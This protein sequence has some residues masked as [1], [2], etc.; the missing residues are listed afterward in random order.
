MALSPKQ[1]VDIMRRKYPNRY[2]NSSDLEIYQDFQQKY[3][4]KKFPAFNPVKQED[5]E[6]LLTINT[7]PS[8]FEWLGTTSFITEGMI[9]EG[10]MGGSGTSDD[11]G[12]FAEG[13]LAGLWH[14]K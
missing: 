5:T 8:V 10:F 12:S 7:N 13:G 2:S 6:D 9:D 1:Y 3:P 4:N 11:M 14:R